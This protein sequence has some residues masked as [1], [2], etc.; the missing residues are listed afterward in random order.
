M[1]NSKLATQRLAEAYADRGD[2]NGWFEE[3]YA[4]AGGD[5][6]KIY[7]A[8]LKPNPL[9]LAWL[10]RGAD[11][12]GKRAVIIGCGLGDDAEAL[13]KYGYRVTAFDLSASAIDM[14]RQRYPNSAVDYLVADLFNTPPEWC[15]GFDLVYECNTIQVFQGPSRVQALKAIADLVAS[16]GGEVLVSCRSRNAGEQP[17]TFPLALDREEISGF[18]RAGLSETL[19]VAYD[20][21]QDPPVPHF[22]ACYTR[23]S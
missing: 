8:D 16:P 4:R 9:L 10:K 2:P 14:C 5:F 13:A 7:W 1:E 6:R 22:F 11:P 20:D 19:F 21:D 23:L 12:A 15:Q 17:D 3:F 18:Q